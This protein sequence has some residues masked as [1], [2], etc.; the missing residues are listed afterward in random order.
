MGYLA[1]IIGAAASFAFGAFWYG[2]F[3]DA[4]KTDSKV[5]LDDDKNPQNM[6]SPVPYVICAVSLVLVAGM[7]RHN[8][9]TAG[10][11][12][13]GK[14]LLSGAGIGLFFVAPWVALFNGYAMQSMRLTLINGGYATIGCA[15]MGAVLGLF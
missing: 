10:I 3:S 15:I 11:D 6:R 14:G 2:V 4:W 9:A 5:P 7:M 12:T 1:V 13:F 8:F